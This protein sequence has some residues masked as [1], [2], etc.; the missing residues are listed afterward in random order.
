MK[1]TTLDEEVEE[2]KG[3][4]TII[5]ETTITVN[6]RNQQSREIALRILLEASSPLFS[7]FWCLFI[8]HVCY[9]LFSA[10]V[11]LDVDND[12]VEKGKEEE[13]GEVHQ[14]AMRKVLLTHPSQLHYLSP[15]GQAIKDLFRDAEKEV[16]SMLQGTWLRYSE[17]D[18]FKLL[19]EDHTVTGTTDLLP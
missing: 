2:Q 9:L 18:A 19:I 8:I 3:T 4:R 14:P 1:T 10:Y 16:I 13:T 15:L 5:M 12:K 7:F 6:K 11:T 17:T